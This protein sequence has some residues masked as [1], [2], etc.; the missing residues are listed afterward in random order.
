M[1][2]TKT[3]F[4]ALG[5]ATAL[6]TTVAAGAQG[7]TTETNLLDFKPGQK[8]QTDN[9]VKST[10]S[11][12]MMGQQMD[13]KADVTV[14]RLLEIKDK[15]DK[16]YN[17]A[18]TITKMATEMDMM[19]QSVTYDSDKKED[20]NSEMG[21]MLKEKI[22][23][24]AS[25][26]MSEDGKIIPAKKDVTKTGDDAAGM[27]SMMKSMGLGDDDAILT[28]DVFIAAPKNI[29]TGSVW[30]DSIIA[31]GQ[32]TYRDYSVKSVQGN[33]AMV[34]IGG[35]LLTDKKMENQGMEMNLVME[36]KITGEM[37][38]D[39]TT[40]V[41]KQRT[42]TVEGNGNIEMMGQQ[43]PMSTKVETTSATKNL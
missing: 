33:E 15:K 28:D 25:H 7:K 13:I 38:M 43:V 42:I 32:K 8:F 20:A 36:S 41:I 40:G 39:I 35:K 27:A 3:L 29:T 16:L 31:E 5:F 22:N 37:T 21:K 23:V 6:M 17:I 10:T 4:R 19:G 14:V 11:M 2:H 9:T 24:P 34:T 18:S 12:E 1:K 30:S 26:E